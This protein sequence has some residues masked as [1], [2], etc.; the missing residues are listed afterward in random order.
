MAPTHSYW[1]QGTL[2]AAGVSDAL[3][4]GRSVRAAAYSVW[5]HIVSPRAQLVT[6]STTEKNMYRCT[7]ANKH[8][9]KTLRTLYV[10][11]HA[12]FTHLR[13]RWTNDIE[14]FVQGL[15]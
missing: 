8:I 10:V 13:C 6:I 12:V 4:L 11:N 9:A 2:D 15:K 14:L 7:H 3:Q 5:G 1:K